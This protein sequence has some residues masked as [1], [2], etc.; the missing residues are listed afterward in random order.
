MNLLTLLALLKEKGIEP[1]TVVYAV[2]LML[3]D[4]AL[5]YYKRDGLLYSYSTANSGVVL[6]V[7]SA[8]IKR[9]SKQD[10]ESESDRIQ[11]LI[12]LKEDLL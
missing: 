2:Y 10:S 4:A 3:A 5:A 9:L 12:P 8:T 7:T 11:I 6:D 1:E